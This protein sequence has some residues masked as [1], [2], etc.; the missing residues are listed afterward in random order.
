[1]SGQ[2]LEFQARAAYQL[3]KY[4]GYRFQGGQ[5]RLRENMKFSPVTSEI[6]AEKIQ[7]DMCCF[8]N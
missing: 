3:R 5:V 8:G 6:Q 1:M 4:K 7:Q 2:F